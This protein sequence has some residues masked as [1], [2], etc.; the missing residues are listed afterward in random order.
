MTSFS[1]SSP[2]PKGVDPPDPQVHL[3]KLTKRSRNAQKSAGADL[4]AHKPSHSNNS[5][6]ETQLRITEN[7]GPDALQAQ[8]PP[9]TAAGMG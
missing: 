2:Q 9:I 3:Q 7:E 8:T 5:Q 1:K 4:H 6:N